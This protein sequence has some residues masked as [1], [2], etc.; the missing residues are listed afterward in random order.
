MT[1]DTSSAPEPEDVPS[2][3]VVLVVRNAAG[4][5]REC[6]QALAAQTYPRV[7]ILAVDDGSTDGSHEQLVHALGEGRVIRNETPLGMAR[8]FDAALSQGVPAEADFLLLLHDDA[9]LDPEVV[10][11]LVDATQ[12]PGVERVGIVG[13]KVV[14]H[15]HPRELRDVGRSADRFGHPYSPLQPGEIDQG[16]FDRVLDVLSVDPCAMLVA[17]EVWRGGGLFDERLGEDG[18]LD[19]CWRARVAGWRVLMT[20]LARVRHRAAGEHD[21]RPGAE[22]SR[23]YEEDRAALASVLKND[24][25][26]TLLWVVPL[27]LA[28]TLF[29]LVY[30]TLSRRFEEAYEL[31]AAV[32]WNVAHLPGTLSRRRGI[33]R[34]RRV[35][36]H[37]L[38][39]FTESA[40]LRLPRWFQTAER[41]LEEQR[42]WGEDEADEPAARRLGHRT[43]SLVSAHPVIVTC[44]VAAIVVAVAVRSLVGSGPLVGAALPTFPS[45]PSGFLAALVSAYRTTPLGG[46]MAASPA[47]GAMS[48]LSFL[49]FGSTAIAQKVMLVGGPVLAGVL[50][51]RAC[52]RLTGRPG[53]AVVAASAYAV[54]ALTLSAFSDGRIALL[55]AIAAMPPIVERLEVAFGSADPPDGRWRFIAG[56]AVTIR[57]RRGVR[58]RRPA[59]ARV[60]RGGPPGPRRRPASRA[61][62]GGAFPRGRR[63][64][65]VLLRADPRRGRR[66]VAGL[67]GRIAQPVATSCDSRS[68]GARARG[69]P[70]SSCRSPPSSASRSRAGLAAARP[71]E[72]PS[73]RPSRSRSRGSPPRGTCRRRSRTRPCT[74]PW[75]P[76]RRPCSSRSASRRPASASNASPSGS[77]RSARR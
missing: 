10:A 45:S 29:R 47:L 39:R 48:G 28:L 4:W 50:C 40:G 25:F 6:L 9:V 77:A 22:R 56:F 34:S 38:R 8:A 65:A 52:A 57:G 68:A 32:G 33:Q 43:V 75:P 44:F 76:R 19:L 3:L 49:T 42:E 55:V 73:A 62:R 41:I 36:D 16:Q 17:R 53:P 14:D 23:R 12:L 31:L 24:G 54:S 30:L 11:R 1:A 2:V 18:D 26:I 59:R 69:R 13:A 61:Q 27:G 72:P 63:R 66:P 15:E 51:Y 74:S 5:L 67:G 35:R 7:G 37:A 64:V 46:T 20:P 58:A 71:S 21:D 70:R 60:A